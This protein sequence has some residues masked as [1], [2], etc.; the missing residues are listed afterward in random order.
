GEP[1]DFKGAII[2]LA[3]RASDYVN[4]SILVVDGGWLGR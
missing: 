2:F 3:S 4:G 1:D